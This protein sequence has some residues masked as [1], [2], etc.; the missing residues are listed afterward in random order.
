MIRLITVII[1]VILAIIV[2]LLQTFLLKKSE[3]K[4]M[5]L[6]PYFIMLTALLVACIMSVMDVRGIFVEKGTLM[7]TVR[8]IKDG[9]TFCLVVDAVTLAINKIK[10][11]D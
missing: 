9:V 6:I 10:K 8:I 4:V 1:C 7:P 2:F 5:H 11:K 3:K